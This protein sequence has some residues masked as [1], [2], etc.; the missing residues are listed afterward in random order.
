MGKV[1]LLGG[2]Y[3]ARS[4][5]ANAQRSINLYPEINPGD[6]P[7][8]TTNYPTPGLTSWGMPPASAVARGTYSATNGQLFV[9]IGAVLYSVN[10]SGG[11]TAIGTL[12]T[13][14]IVSGAITAPGTGY[15]PVSS[16]FQAPLTGGNGSGATATIVTDGSGAVIQVALVSGGTGYLSGDVLSLT[17]DAGMGFT[18]T[19]NAVDTVT[20]STL[21]T[22]VSMADN[23]LALILVDG[24]ANGWAIDLDDH[25][26]G[27]IISAAF[28]GADRV[29]YVDTFF[30]FNRPGT[31]Q[32]YISA[33]DADFAGLTEGGI[34][35]GHL[36]SGGASYDIYTYISLNPVSLLGGTGTGATGTVAITNFTTGTISSFTLVDPGTGYSIGDLL[37]LPSGGLFHDDF[38]IVTPGAGY[39]N[40]TFPSPAIGGSGTGGSVVAFF[41]GGTLQLAGQINTGSGYK[42]TDVLS[43]S[44]GS[45]AGA[46]LSPAVVS[47]GF[48]YQVDTVANTAFDPL[49]IAAKTGYA[50]PIVTLAV[51]HREIWLIGRY[52][53]EVWY[54]TGASDF[55]FGIMPG[56]FIEHGC[57]AKYSLAKQDLSLFWLSQ[58]LQGQCI[59]VQGAA[60]QA[61]RISTHAIEAAIQAYATVSDAI[62][63]TYQEGGHVFY[64]L[65]FPTANATWDYDVTTE[66]WHQRASMDPANGA[67]NRHRANCA[68][69]AYGLNLIGDYQNGTLYTLDQNNYTENGIPMPRIRSFPHIQDE[70]RRIHYRSFIADM[71]VGTLPNSVTGN[72][73]RLSLRWSDDRGASW[74]S[75]VEQSLGS[76][77]QYLTS[78]KWNRL[79]MA[80]DRVFEL[81]WSAAT[82]TALNGAYI[83]ARASET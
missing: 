59:V 13:N 71:E 73:P 63:F 81:S 3:Q 40:G 27:P 61:H 9:V 79:G 19:A 5:I 35:S 41:S 39:V 34:G 70:N 18:W 23:G 30:V 10:P 16:T 62:G 15:V 17:L 8:P 64:Q 42:T 72:P 56:V 52:T 29:D 38:T 14:A 80:R 20:P 32:F 45:G 60:Y 28:Y 11:F 50:D 24:T 82:K 47:G 37:S 2:A 75:A 65:T 55:T 78:I 4:L 46:T 69:F 1:A 12:I 43:L 36:V 54:D 58:D 21:T 44:V 83:D 77:G 33:S 57:V 66:L 48:S 26:F 68:A 74:G 22:P 25:G 51:M 31:N 6:S 7:F 76:G 49:D 53:T 67:L